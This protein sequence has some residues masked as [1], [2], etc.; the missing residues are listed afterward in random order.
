MAKIS[1]LT[2]DGRRYSG[3][4]DQGGRVRTVQE[5]KDKF[6]TTTSQVI[7]REQLDKILGT[8]DTLE[9]VDK[10]SE[11]IDLLRVPRPQAR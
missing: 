6:I 10:V 5:V 9:S 4:S 3:R 2:K 11:L 1:I 8:I 7:S